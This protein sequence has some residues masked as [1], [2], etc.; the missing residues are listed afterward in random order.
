M[1]AAAALTRCPCGPG[2]PV[3]RLLELRRWQQLL[4]SRVSRYGSQ[5]KVLAV[6][7]SDYE[8]LLSALRS[9]VRAPPS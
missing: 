1:A 9:Q 4:H 2:G 6:I 8:Q 7:K 3:G 5:A